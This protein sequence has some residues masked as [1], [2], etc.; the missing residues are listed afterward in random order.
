MP[1]QRRKWRLCAR[2]KECNNC[3]MS[4]SSWQ[5]K[6]RKHSY[7]ARRTWFALKCFLEDNVR[8]HKPLQH[9]D[10]RP[11]GDQGEKLYACG[12]CTNDMYQHG[13]R[14]PVMFQCGHSMCVT[15]YNEFA[16]ITEN[17]QECPFCR[18][19]I[20]TVTELFVS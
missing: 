18:A 11:T 4:I 12:I 6:A 17:E 14:K 7:N 3:R 8:R 9:I 13:A 16:N 1:P 2:H 15:C 20:T 5:L 19:K 10:I